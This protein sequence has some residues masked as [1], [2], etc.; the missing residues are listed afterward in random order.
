MPLRKYPRF[1]ADL[2]VSFSGEN[3]AG[4]GILIDI[5]L[6]GCA[7]SSD[8]CPAFGSV[9]TLR[10]HL[11]GDDSPLVINLAAVRWSDR[12]KFGVEFIQVGAAHLERL[13]ALVK[14][15]E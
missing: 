10:I 2:P 9:I 8:T 12:E 7:V 5:S 15:F 11:Y 14:T 3:I 1:V 13:Q 6:G 4:E